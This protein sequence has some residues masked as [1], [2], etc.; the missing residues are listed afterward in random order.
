M[1]AKS[2]EH[3]LGHQRKVLERGDNF[4][5]TDN[6]E[7]GRLRQNLLTKQNEFDQTED[8][9]KKLENEI[10]MWVV[11]TYILNLTSSLLPQTEGGAW[12]GREGIQSTT[13]EGRAGTAH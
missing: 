12:S 3:Q 10:A 6:S 1:E 5:D 11:I 9:L 13:Q 7:N 8:T 2:L 4:P